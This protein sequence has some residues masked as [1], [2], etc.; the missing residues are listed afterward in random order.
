MLYSLSLGRLFYNL[1]KIQNTKIKQSYYTVQLRK[2]YSEAWADRKFW[3]SERSGKKDVTWYRSLYLKKSL[4]LEGQRTAECRRLD[5]TGWRTETGGL[6]TGEQ[7]MD[8]RR[9]DEKK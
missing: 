2:A 9:L 1:Q 6:K 5:E 3:D 7:K 8:D 4:W